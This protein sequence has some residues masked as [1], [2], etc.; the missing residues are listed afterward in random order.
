MN[1]RYLTRINLQR[2]SDDVLFYLTDVPEVIDSPEMRLLDKGRELSSLRNLALKGRL[3]ASGQR[4]LSRLVREINQLA[5][6]YPAFPALK[7]TKRR[8]VAS[9]WEAM[10]RHPGYG[11][12]SHPLA[13]H[14]ILEFV[15]G[16]FDLIAVGLLDRLRKCQSCGKWI[17][18]RQSNQRLCGTKHC[19]NRDYQSNPKVRRKRNAARRKKRKEEA[20]EAARYRTRTSGVRNRDRTASREGRR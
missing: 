5:E 14:M 7:E 10:Y 16:I 4:R 20:A 18:A 19:R 3:D 11:R 17:I 1:S 6:A 2:I 12:T 8:W 9:E 13:G 15:R